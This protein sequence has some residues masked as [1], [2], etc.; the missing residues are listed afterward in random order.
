MKKI[1]LKQFQSIIFLLTITM[2]FGI[3]LSNIVRSC[4][5][6]FWISVI[7]GILMGSIIVLMFSKIWFSSSNALFIDNNKF[8]NICYIII[9]TFY[10]IV[11]LSTLTNLIVS[12]YLTKL[13]PFIICL[14]LIFLMIYGS[15]DKEVLGRISILLLILCLILVSIII[16]TVSFQ[17]KIDNFLPLFNTKWQ[18][19][20][21]EACNYA[22]YSTSPLLL[23][24]LYSPTEVN[25]IK[26]Y[27]IVK[28][29]FVASILILVAFLLTVGVMGTD[30]VNLYRYP[31][32]IVLKIVSV[33]NFINNIENITAFFWIMIYIVFS[34]TTAL[35]LKVTIQNLCNK[36]Y[37]F[38]I[39]LFL[40]L[41]L[42]HFTTFKRITWLLFLYK[43]EAYLLLGCLIL[44]FL[45]NIKKLK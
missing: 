36:K 10:T 45:I 44:F 13:S 15:K 12:I 5:E 14:P 18:I 25:G 24:S 16:A 4:K 6:S 37:L 17:I 29:Y 19:I 33:F 9:I 43:Y 26:K 40:I 27:S 23:L 32:Y 20:L 34:L 21:K 31:E 3:G 42:L 28:T 1:S 22:F 7:L 2:F 11:C 39:Y 41:I 38:P 30:L 35:S 8:K